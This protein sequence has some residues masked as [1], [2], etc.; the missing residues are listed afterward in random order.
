MILVVSSLADDH[1]VPVVDRLTDRGADVRLLDLSAFPTRLGLVADYH[2]EGSRQ[3]RLVDSDEDI[4]LSTVN[5]V[6]W[7]RPQPFHIDPDVSD[8][9]DAQFAYTE[10][11]QAMTGLFHALDAV[12]MNPPSKDDTAGYKLYQLKIAQEVGLPVPPT[13]VTNDPTAARAFVAE[14]GPGDTIYKAFLAQPEA[15]RETRVMTAT[16]VALLDEV[17]LA[18]VIFQEYVPAD[19]DLRITAVGDELFAVAIDASDTDYPIDYRMTL[20]QAHVEPHELPATIRE[21]LRTLMNRLGLVYG[22]IDMRRTPDGEYVFL[23]I[24]P[25]GLWLFTEEPTGLP[26]TDTVVDW[27]LAQDHAQTADG[28]G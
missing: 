22:A 13:R 7:R 10:C 26:I 8:P 2:P 11:T 3:S 21:K 28:T 9:T 14:H 12:W 17:E 6:W 19:F 23:E 16:E 5:A 27:F 20:G 18:P 25:S 1:T 24:N 15:W 4:D